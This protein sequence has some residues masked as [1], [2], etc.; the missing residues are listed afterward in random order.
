[1]SKSHWTSFV[2]V[3]QLERVYAGH[4]RCSQISSRREGQQ[5]QIPHETALKILLEWLK[6]IS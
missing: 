6:M 3:K 2:S 1:M 4:L 5:L